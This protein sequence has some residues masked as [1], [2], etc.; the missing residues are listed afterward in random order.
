M[1]KKLDYTKHA[2][3]TYREVTQ[4]ILKREN[5]LDFI[6]MGRGKD[7]NCAPDP[8]TRSNK[9][10]N[11]SKWEPLPS[12]V[13]DFRLGSH[14]SFPTLTRNLWSPDDGFCASGQ[15]WSP[16][17]DGVPPHERYSKGKGGAT[18]GQPLFLE[19]G[20]ILFVSGVCEDAIKEIGAV[21][22]LDE[23]NENELADGSISQKQLD[24][25]RITMEQTAK[26]VIDCVGH[27]ELAKEP[28]PRGTRSYLDAYSKTFV[29]DRNKENRRCEP[30]QGFFNFFSSSQPSPPELIALEGPGLGLGALDMHFRR[31]RRRFMVSNKGYLGIVP[32]DAKPT[33]LI[34]VLWGCSV[35]VI[36]RRLP[37]PHNLFSRQRS[38][39]RYQFIG[40]R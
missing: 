9:G 23:L 11:G 25:H 20:K 8:N 24:H 38:V 21:Y 32:P 10:M 34:C 6:C 18:I 40:E 28:Y 19:S 22:S 1:L 13:P 35:P 16:S 15:R 39:D 5:D 2:N 36:L 26:M 17:Q 27:N 31:A 14:D 33:D 3:V 7:R 30:G 29:C 12:W 37:R 4:H